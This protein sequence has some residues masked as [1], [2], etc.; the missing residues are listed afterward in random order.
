MGNGFEPTA[1]SAEVATAAQGPAAAVAARPRAKVPLSAL[2]RLKSGARWFYWVAGLSL[3]NTVSAF[4][5]GHMHFVVGL[6]ITQVVDLVARKA[7]AAA[8]LPALVIDV[9]IAGAFLVIGLWSSRCNQF[10]FGIGMLLYAADGALLFLAHDYLSVAF[11]GL[12]LFYMYRGFA[13]AQQLRGLAELGKARASA[14]IG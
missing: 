5:G 12:A 4:A 13:A 10:A 1:S 8:T 9:M 14:S 3:V 7:G 2:S 6:G 11:H